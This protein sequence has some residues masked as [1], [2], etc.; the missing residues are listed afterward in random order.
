MELIDLQNSLKF[1][2]FYVLYTNYAQLCVKYI[3]HE[4]HFFSLENVI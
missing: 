4:P 2:L 3:V 1:N